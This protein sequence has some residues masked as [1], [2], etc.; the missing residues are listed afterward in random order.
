MTIEFEHL[1]QPPGTPKGNLTLANNQQI[2]EP[3]LKQAVFKEQVRIF[4]T[5]KRILH[6]AGPLSSAYFAFLMSE[7][8]ALTPILIWWSLL[9]VVDSVLVLAC[10]VY[11]RKD[12]SHV[13]RPVWLQAHIFG[14]VLSGFLWGVSILLFYTP[15]L[16]GQLYN[17]V[18]LVAVSSFSAVVL[19]PVRAAYLGFFVSI[20]MPAF[21]FFLWLGDFAHV[22][23]AM[24]ILV[25]AVITTVFQSSATEHFIDSIEKNYRSIELSKALSL[26]LEQIK[27]LASRD[28]LTGLYNRRFGMEGLNHELNRRE[29]YQENLTLAIMDIDHFKQINDKHGHLIGDAV[30]VEF[31]RRIT[32]LLRSEDTFF[33]YGGE[34]FVVVFPHTNLQDAQLVAERM[35][36]TICDV[37]FVVAHKSIEVTVSIGISEFESNDTVEHRISLADNALYKAK[38]LGRNRVEVVGT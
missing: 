11:L 37:D 36:R 23:Q 29:R 34:E 24:G 2:D 20:T 26:S 27:E 6:A 5:R 8:V 17:I 28:Y 16:Q 21:I 25:I 18:T 7:Y 4:I 12:V 15:Q 1:S 14:L 30:L 13:N 9:A 10:T 33:R 38:N 22:N 31:A 32:E 19:I 35:R 3:A